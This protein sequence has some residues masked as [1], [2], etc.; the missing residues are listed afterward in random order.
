[1]KVTIVGLGNAARGDDGVG[2]RVIDALTSAALP[3]DTFLAR[4]AD[5]AALL[6]LLEPN[7]AYVLVD[8]VAAPEQVGALHCFEPHEL[9]PGAGP[10]SRSSTSSHALGVAES[11]GIAT[12]LEQV[13]PQR[14]RLLGIAI[15]PRQVM[16]GAAL[17]PELER[18]IPHAGA[19]A[20]TIA[21]RL[22]DA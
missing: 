7:R 10:L 5:G 1:M 21:A 22:R 15:D 20:L 4:A 2:P 16:L 3:K 9:R 13:N 17:S 11:L 14:V 8:A 12:A 18:V 19:E 6:E